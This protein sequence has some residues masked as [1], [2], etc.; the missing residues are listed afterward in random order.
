MCVCV[1]CVCGVCLCACVHT[2]TYNGE[3]IKYY[4]A[5]NK[6]KI[7]AFITT[8][9]N[10]GNVLKIYQDILFD[11]NYTWNL[12]QKN[13]DYS[14]YW[15]TKWNCIYKKKNYRKPTNTLKLTNCHWTTTGPKEKK[16][17][18]QRLPSIQWKWIYNI[19][20]VME[21]AYVLYKIKHFLHV[22][23]KKHITDIPQNSIW[24]TVIEISNCTLKD[25]V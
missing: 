21:T 15:S 14:I 5:L 11:I 10:L 17:R 3:A 6:K 12:K 22:T 7:Q 20:K 18:N 4:L 25:N 2:H 19:S 24:K 23:I 8:W 16:E 13:V 1:F 9:M